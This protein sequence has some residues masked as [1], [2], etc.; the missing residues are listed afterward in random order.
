MEGK[1][2]FVLVL[3]MLWS[4]W[5]IIIPL[6]LAFDYSM[7]VSFFNKLDSTGGIFLGVYLFILLWNQ[8]NMIFKDFNFFRHGLNLPWFHSTYFDFKSIS[9]VARLYVTIAKM[10][11]WHIQKFL[12]DQ[13]FV[14]RFF[15]WRGHVFDAW[16]AYLPMNWLMK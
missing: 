15:H 2:S 9:L 7:T 10:F 6:R 16:Q 1:A 8:I 13:P 3:T 12:C 5:K 11:S 4:S 14:S